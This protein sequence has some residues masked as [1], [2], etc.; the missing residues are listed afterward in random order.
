MSITRQTIKRLEKEL[1]EIEPKDI[2]QAVCE[3]RDG[4]FYYNSDGGEKVYKTAK[5]LYKKEGIKGH[6]I[7]LD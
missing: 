4:L 1:T 7:I 3:E 6:L 2:K 5:E